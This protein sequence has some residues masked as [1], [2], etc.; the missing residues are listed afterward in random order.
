[1]FHGSEEMFTKISTSHW[2]IF[3]SR[4]LSKL[5]LAAQIWTKES[6]FLLLAALHENLGSTWAVFAASGNGMSEATGKD[7]NSGGCCFLATV[8]KGRVGREGLAAPWVF[9]LP[10]KIMLGGFWSSRFLYFLSHFRCW[11][12]CF[13]GR[14]TKIC[15]GLVFAW[16]GGQFKRKKPF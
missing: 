5:T 15:H 13:N 16:R 6:I 7:K 8:R 9:T 10:E 14:E 2:L 12:Q 1:M 3:T 4:E 11:G